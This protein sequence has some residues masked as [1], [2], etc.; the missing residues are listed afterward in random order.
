MK[1]DK[2]PHR[3]YEIDEEGMRIQLDAMSFLEGKGGRLMPIRLTPRARHGGVTAYFD[4]FSLERDEIIAA[5]TALTRITALSVDC[6]T[7]DR[8]CISAN[9]WNVFREKEGI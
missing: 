2:T 7:D 8:I 3:N 1:K 5:M 6:T 9:V 4:H